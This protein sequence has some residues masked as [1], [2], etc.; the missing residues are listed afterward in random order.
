MK[1]S[2]RVRRLDPRTLNR[3]PLT[4]NGSKTVLVHKVLC[5]CIL[6]ELQ[7]AFVLLLQRVLWLSSGTLSSQRHHDVSVMILKNKYYYLIEAVCLIAADICSV[8][9]HVTLNHSINSAD[10][11]SKSGYKYGV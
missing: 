9:I 8:S 6:P 2:I 10:Q 3:H 4:D 1:R 7:K 11:G 5:Q